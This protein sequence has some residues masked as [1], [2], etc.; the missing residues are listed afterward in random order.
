MSQP[1]TNYE[2]AGE[3]TTLE[4]EEIFLSQI[5]SETDLTVEIAGYSVQ[6]RPIKRVVLGTPTE[7]TLMIVCLIHGNE[8]ASR[9]AALGKIRDLAYST[10]PEVLTYL[11]THR[12]VWIPTASPDTFPG[13]RNNMN[14]VNPNRDFFAL[15]QPEPRAIVGTISEYA[16]HFIVDAHEYF[17][18]GEDW[19]GAQGQMPSAHPAITTLE[20]VVFT[21]G[22]NVLGG[23]GY[24]SKHYGVHILPRAGLSGYASTRHAVGLLSETNALHGDIK[25]R[26][27]VQR[28]IFDMVIKWHYENASLISAAR[29]KSLTWAQTSRGDDRFKIRVEYLG[30][31]TTE[32][33]SFS[34]Y[35]LS[36]SLDPE[37]MALHGIIVDD[38]LFASIQQTS[39]MI[40]PQV[41][42]PDAMDRQV[43]AVRVPWP[44]PEYPE[45][46]LRVHTGGSVQDVTR[47]RIHTGGSVQDVTRMRIH[48]GGAIRDI[49]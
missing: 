34:G 14:N 42:D 43:D 10:D 47:M 28:I 1:Q 32:T 49:L 39:R 18:G 2:L 45:L 24:S 7:G 26:V 6:N 21:H 12:I 29:N 25:D 19:W 30:R 44:E 41:L 17:A 23:Y 35:Q 8:Q 16:P 37:L 3:W 48:T 11:E 15:T 38:D 9:E 13:R 5:Q 31:D 40:L 27:D 22:C 4:Q 46:G 36:E 20:E 33:A